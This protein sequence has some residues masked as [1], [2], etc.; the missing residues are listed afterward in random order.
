M[1]RTAREASPV[2]R[3]GALGMVASLVSFWWA[4]VTI[5]KGSGDLDLV[6]AVGLTTTVVL[7]LSG[8]WVPRVRPYAVGAALG[9][10]AGCL[11]AVMIAGGV[12]ATSG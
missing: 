8:M 4:V 1:V 9:V 3:A 10:A 12:L 11:L 5:D 6:V 7:A 2:A